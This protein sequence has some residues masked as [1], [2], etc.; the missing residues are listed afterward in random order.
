M[1]EAWKGRGKGSLRTCSEAQLISFLASV[2]IE[3]PHPHPGGSLPGVLLV[4]PL[5]I[6]PTTTEG[7]Q[8][9]AGSGHKDHH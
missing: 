7:R 6:L 2:V 8:T 3:C 1:A 4:R 9:V 5:L